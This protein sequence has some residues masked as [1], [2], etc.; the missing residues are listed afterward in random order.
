[1]YKPLG[2]GELQQTNLIFLLADK[3]VKIPKRI[4]EDVILKV[5][6]FYFP[7]DFVVLETER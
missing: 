5:D 2:L 4:V 3:F 6:E 1:M 7:T